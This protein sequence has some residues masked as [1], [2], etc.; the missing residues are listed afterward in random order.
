MLQENFRTLYAELNK[1]FWWE[2]EKPESLKKCD[3]GGPAQE[4]SGQNKDP[5]EIWV[6]G[7]MCAILAKNIASPCPCPENLSEAEFKSNTLMYLAEEIFRRG[8]GCESITNAGL[9]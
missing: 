9:Q 8:S 6:R 4:V 7:H 2:F 1:V 5:I 3:S